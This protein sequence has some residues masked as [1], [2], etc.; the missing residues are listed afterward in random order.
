MGRAGYRGQARKWRVQSSTSNWD[1]IP[2]DTV[3]DFISHPDFRR[4]PTGIKLLSDLE[5]L[6]NRG[7]NYGARV[8]G[9][10]HPEVTGN[11]LFWIVADDAGEL[12]MSDDENPENKKRSCFLDSW[13]PPREWTR[14]PSQQSQS[15]RLEGG[16]RYYIEA[17]HKQGSAGD[18]LAVAW[19]PPGAQR[20]II[21]GR[22]LSPFS[23]TN[24][25][26]ER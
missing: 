2:G 11:Y 17:L 21:P 23:E 18:Y 12:W 7:Q 4:G 13:A 15:I 6:S 1:G 10:L 8:R 22:V 16:R 5:A 24:A 3:N 25:G 19:Q 9:Y 14:Q 20:E 26:A